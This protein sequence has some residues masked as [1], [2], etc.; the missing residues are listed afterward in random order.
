[1][2][3][4]HV[5]KG[6]ERSMS[7]KGRDKASTTMPSKYRSNKANMIL[8]TCVSIRHN[9]NSGQQCR[10]QEKNGVHHVPNNA[11]QGHALNMH[12]QRY[13]YI[14]MCVSIYL[15]QSSTRLF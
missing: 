8:T 6:K 7:R 13:I 4:G 10:R 15:Y 14:Y 1:M 5:H 12:H 2:T 11:I 3:K 9:T